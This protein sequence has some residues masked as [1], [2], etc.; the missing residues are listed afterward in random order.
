MS[1]PQH[2]PER[3]LPLSIPQLE[4]LVAVADLRTWTEAAAE[5]EV[6]QSAL[7]QGLAE[8]E[9]RIGRKI[10]EREGRGRTIAPGAQPIVSYARR[11]L[12]DTADLGRWLADERLGR[13]GTV[14][15]GIID[16]AVTLH[17]Q[18]ELQEFRQ[19][20]DS[21][22]FK[23]TVA[24][25][26]VLLEQLLLGDFDLAILVEPAVRPPGVDWTHLLDEDLAVYAPPGSQ[27]GPP[28][29]WGPW[30]AFPASSHTTNHAARALSQL[31]VRFDVVAES[32]QPDVICEMVRLG[33]GWAVLPATQAET[34]GIEMQRVRQTPLA[35]RTVVAAT[36]SPSAENPLAEC[37]LDLLK[38][39]SG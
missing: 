11:V 10:F 15:L 34:S 24:P 12:A 27:V 3:L 36:R 30:V 14:R 17:F 18:D 38:K 39:E 23:L 6:T 5:L 7:S 25:S 28:A 9:R 4:Y 31:G 19:P 26:A 8:L 29:E 22:Q 13:A 37:L 20:L 32:H 35:R 21:A 1:R 16:A 2:T 33:V